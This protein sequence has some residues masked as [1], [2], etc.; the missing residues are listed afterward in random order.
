MSPD[1]KEI[2]DTFGT[3]ELELRGPVEMKVRHALPV[4]YRNLDINFGF[5]INAFYRNLLNVFINKKIQ[6]FFYF[7]GQRC[8]YYVLVN[9]GAG[10][11]CDVRL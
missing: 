9:G 4:R 8:N 5:F 3:F 7:A 1:T 6:L 11:T 10:G 2:L